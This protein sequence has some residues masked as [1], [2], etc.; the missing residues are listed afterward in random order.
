LIEITGGICWE[1]SYEIENAMSGAQ[2]EVEPV[3]VVNGSFG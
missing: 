1:F 3:R 2:E